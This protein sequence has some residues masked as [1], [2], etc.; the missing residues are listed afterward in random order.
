MG[1]ALKG[2]IPRAWVLQICASSQSLIT[3]LQGD[4]LLPLAVRWAENF[5]LL[6]PMGPQAV[7]F[8]VIVRDVGLNFFSVVWKTKCI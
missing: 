2:K 5:V 7:C 6:V 8:L 4:N 1:T 3:I